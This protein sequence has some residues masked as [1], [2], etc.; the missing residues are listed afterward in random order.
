MTGFHKGLVIAAVLFAATLAAVL[1]SATMPV[2]QAIHSWAVSVRTPGG[3]ALAKAVTTLGIAWVAAPLTTLIAFAAT[4]GP[5]RTRAV[6]AAIALAVIAAGG[7]CRTAISI[8]VHRAR[9]PLADW[10][11]TTAGFSFP[12]GHTTEATLAAGL[13]AWLIARRLTR[14]WARTLIWL[15]AAACAAVVGFTRVYLGVHWP[16]DVF[17][18]WC[19]GV[20][21]LTLAAVVVIRRADQPL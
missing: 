11:T 20:L 10:A 14:P 9:P 18:G 7:F 1:T 13:S 12:S 8:A 21:W 15:A 6:H 16:T 3:I 17:G 5:V 2:D 4:P 19:F